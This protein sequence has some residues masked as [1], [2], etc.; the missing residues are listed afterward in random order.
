MKPLL[1]APLLLLGHPLLSALAGSGAEPTCATAPT[2]TTPTTP[3][4]AEP[5]Q[6]KISAPAVPATPA[7][8]PKSQPPRHLFM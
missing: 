8:H 3:R 7:S 2:Q 1:F 5:A 4:A 6:K